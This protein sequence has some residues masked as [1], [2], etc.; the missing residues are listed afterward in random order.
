[1]ELEIKGVRVRVSFLFVS[2]AA[3]YILL[4]PAAVSA[5]FLLAITAHETGH[6]IAMFSLGEP[7]ASIELRS[8]GIRITRRSPLIPPRRELVILAAGPAVNLLLSALFFL[9]SRMPGAEPLLTASSINLLVALF[10]LFPTGCLDGGGL[11]RC[12]LGIALSPG[13]ARRVYL[14][15]AW[16][17]LLPLAA[18]GAYLL[19]V[20][21]HSP[22]LLITAVYL[23]VTLLRDIGR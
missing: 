20:P 23:T 19:I 4:T 15:V 18:F 14:A 17:F 10:N 7:P 9:A 12:L 8:F 11:M 21:P 16:L 6:L 3:L 22:S 13:A 5:F 2:M 1:M